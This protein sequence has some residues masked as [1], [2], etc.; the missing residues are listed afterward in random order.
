MG[1]YLQVQLHVG[2]ARWVI[3]AAANADLC[4]GRSIEIYLPPA[5]LWLLPRDD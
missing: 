1:G 3:N 2:N 4:P 5:Q